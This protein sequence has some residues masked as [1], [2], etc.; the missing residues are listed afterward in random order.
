MT[1]T[2]SDLYKRVDHGPGLSLGKAVSRGII[3]EV[4]Y[5]N[6]LAVLGTTQKASTEIIM[7]KS[8]PI[9]K[10]GKAV[11]ACAVPDSKDHVVVSPGLVG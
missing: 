2:P 10:Q 11:Y 1:A 7:I 9:G 6:H 4:Q 3:G 5:H 8:T